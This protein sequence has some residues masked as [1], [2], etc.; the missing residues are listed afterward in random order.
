VE[1][2]AKWLNP[3]SG[4]TLSHEIWVNDGSYERR[5]ADLTTVGTG[6]ATSTSVSK[7]LHDLGAGD[8][9]K[10]E[11]NHDEGSDLTLD[12]GKEWTYATFTRIG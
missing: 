2:A 6:G 5:A 9:V 11:V 3:T 1:S 4:T 12:S 10:I 8:T 7:V